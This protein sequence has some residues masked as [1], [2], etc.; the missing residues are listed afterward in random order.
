MS[1]FWTAL[2][3]PLHEEGVRNGAGLYSWNILLSSFEDYSLCPAQTLQWVSFP[4]EENSTLSHG[5]S[6]LAPDT[7]P[8]WSHPVSLLLMALQSHQPPPNSWSLSTSFLAQLRPFA[9]AGPS[10]CNVRPLMIARADP[11]SSLRLSLNIISLVRAVP[12]HLT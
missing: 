8:W 5:P 10:F 1:L 2:D 3:R 7:S 11:L 9:H 4:S 12:E 6:V